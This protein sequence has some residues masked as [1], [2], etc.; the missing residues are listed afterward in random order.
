L[1]ACLLELLGRR[2]EV[3]EFDAFKA[4]RLVD[5]DL[6]SETFEDYG[7]FSSAVYFLG[8]ADRT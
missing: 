1:L 2:V 8:V 4:A 3:I 6:T 5:R 7:I